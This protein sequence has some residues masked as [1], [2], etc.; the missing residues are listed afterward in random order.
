MTLRLRPEKP[1]DDAFLRALVMDT[2]AEELGAD[3]WPEPIRSQ[4]L[5]LQ[6]GNRRSPRPDASSFVVQTDGQDAGWL[7]TRPTAEC[8]WLVEIM[9]SRSLR[10]QG[11][12]TAV[13]REVLAAGK[14]VRLHVNVTNVAAQRLYERLGF[15]RT[16]DTGVQYLMEHP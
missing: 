14:P 11:I 10:G 3:H 12:G 16:E 9:V 15:R 1:T 2:I 5:G 13:I 7:L 6:Y 8:I 4:V